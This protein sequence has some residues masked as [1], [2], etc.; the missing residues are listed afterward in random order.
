MH[1]RCGALPIL[2]IAVA[3]AAGSSSV[4]N[5]RTT[6]QA[7]RATSPTTLAPDGAAWER[8]LH[9]YLTA[10]PRC[11]SVSRSAFTACLKAA[12]QKWFIPFTQARYDVVEVDVPRAKGACKGRLL[13]YLGAGGAGDA[14]ITTMNFAQ[15]DARERKLSLLSQTLE[16]LMLPAFGAT[17]KA[18]K[19]AEAA[20]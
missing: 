10:A 13:D 6:A 17:N 16:Q 4:A 3:V 2:L 12:F 15:K 20:C 14:L 5:A 7:A 1:P 8:G 11:F 9:T 18:L 19:A